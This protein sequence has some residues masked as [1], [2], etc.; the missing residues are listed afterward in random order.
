M[1]SLVGCTG[2]VGSNLAAETHFDGL[3]HSTDVVD[4]YGTKPD[5]LV[6]AGVS[7]E[8]F[9]A[10]H[11]PEKDR[12]VVGTA[13]ENMKRIAPKRLVLIS[14]IDVYK[15]PVDVDEDSRIETDGLLPYGLNRY[16]LEQRV[17]E[18]FPD[19]L[20]VRLPG[21]YGK[22]LKKNFLY[23]FIHV[24]PSMLTEAKFGELCAKDP[25]IRQYYTKQE[26]GFFKC[27]PLTP[28]QTEKLK[29]YFRAVG[30]SALNFTDSRG[31]FQF[32]NLAYL[33]RHIQTALEHGLKKVNL[34]TEPV[35]VS[36]IYRAVKGTDWKNELPNPV[37]CYRARTKYSELFGGKNGYIFDRK[38]VIEDV[39]EFIKSN[40]SEEKPG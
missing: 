18:E 1:K 38:F 28:G 7:S 4:A 22:G 25:L 35:T 14:T 29:E 17:E 20:V 9:L 30:F 5:L 37:P 33:W 2:F 6:Y 15:T 27:I 3:Y 31:A 39:K 12:N 32:Y 36:E 24:I 26:N 13:F 40:S 21:L 34:I 11:N 23:D 8:K 19:H 10:D 16:D